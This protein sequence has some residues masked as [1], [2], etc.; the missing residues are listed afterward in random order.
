M[1]QLERVTAG[2]VAMCTRR[3]FLKENLKETLEAKKAQAKVRG[4]LACSSRTPR[5]LEQP[6]RFHERDVFA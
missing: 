3:A 2:Y 4:I 5:V 6:Q 1:V